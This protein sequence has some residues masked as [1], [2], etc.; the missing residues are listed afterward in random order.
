MI[1][2]TITAILFLSIYTIH[3]KKSDA[4]NQTGKIDVTRITE[5]DNFGFV[6]SQVD[7][8]D[9]T[10]DN[11]WRA[12]ELALFQTPTSTQ[13]A[14]TQ[15]ASVEIKPGFPNPNSTSLFNF[16]CSTTKPTFIQLV[17]VD[18]MLSI[19]DIFF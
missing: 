6:V 17:T 16:T 15:R 8:T 18:S 1:K 4:P 5:T 19:K 7:N 9:W 14:N 11:T 2:K 10:L 3:C 12:E 13:L